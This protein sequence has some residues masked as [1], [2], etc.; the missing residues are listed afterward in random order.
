[1]FGSALFLGWLYLDL[2]CESAP[3]GDHRLPHQIR[4]RIPC[5]VPIEAGDRGARS[6]PER[7]EPRKDAARRQGA[8]A[9]A[10]AIR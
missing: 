5:G 10:P 8:Y 1:M 2:V 7:G 6:Y 4:D 9:P 3:H